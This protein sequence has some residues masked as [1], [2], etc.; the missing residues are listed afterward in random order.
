MRWLA[1]P[2]GGGQRAVSRFLLR[3]LAYLVVLVITA[4]MVAYFL[5]A[6]QLNP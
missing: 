4:T 6:T 5:A 3:R 2:S 1:F